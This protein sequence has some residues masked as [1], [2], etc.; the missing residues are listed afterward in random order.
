VKKVLTLMLA[1]H[2]FSGN[3]LMAEIGKLPFLWQHFFQHQE[4]KKGLTLEEFFAIHYLRNQHGGSDLEHHHLPLLSLHIVPASAALR[5][6]QMLFPSYESSDAGRD[7]LLPTSNLL[8]SSDFRGR[9]LKPPAA[10]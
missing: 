10:C 7:E 3:V 8:T 2:L 4:D 5:P 6:E 1:V 9:L